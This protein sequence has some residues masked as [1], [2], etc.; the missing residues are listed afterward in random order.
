[1]TC[2]DILERMEAVDSLAKDIYPLIFKKGIDVADLAAHFLDMRKKVNSIRRSTKS[3]MGSKCFHEDP[4]CIECISDEKVLDL[5]S[6]SIATFSDIQKT[7]DQE[8]RISK[9]AFFLYKFLLKNRLKKLV[10]EQHDALAL[11]ESFK[12]EPGEL[13]TS[14]QLLHAAGH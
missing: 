5:F 14:E 2:D 6:S 10:D 1:M 7:L 4:A 13:L 8:C 3:I 11:A 9:I 12:G